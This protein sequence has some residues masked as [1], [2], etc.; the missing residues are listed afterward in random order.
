MQVQNSTLYLATII[1]ENTIFIAAEL[2]LRKKYYMKLFLD[3]IEIFNNEGIIY[4][5]ISIMHVER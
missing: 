1:T 3:K 5:L 2:Q 4:V